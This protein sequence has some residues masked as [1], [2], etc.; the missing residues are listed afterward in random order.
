M[1]FGDPSFKW[2]GLNWEFWSLSFEFGVQF[3]AAGNVIFA[4]GSFNMSFWVLE[5]VEKSSER[6]QEAAC[7]NPTDVSGTLPK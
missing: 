7:T 2:V 4:S 5:D 3:V 6:S 1:H